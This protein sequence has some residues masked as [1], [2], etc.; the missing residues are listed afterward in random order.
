MYN[1]YANSYYPTSC[2]P[3]PQGFGGDNGTLWNMYY[4]DNVNPSL[5]HTERYSYDGENRLITTQGTGNSTYDLTFS[6]DRYGNMT[7]QTNGSTSGPCPNYSFDQSTN[8]ITGFGYDADG[9]VTSDT[10]G[11]TYNWDAEGRMTSS[12]EGGTTYP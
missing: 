10:Q 12:V 1:F 9:D 11:D 2:S 6:Y 4:G 3:T 7:C 5:S 8:R